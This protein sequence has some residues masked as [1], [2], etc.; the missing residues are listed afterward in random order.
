MSAAQEAKE[1]FGL[2]VILD[3][4]VD[5]HKI[6]FLGRGFK[7]FVPQGAKV[8]FD[9][10]GEVYAIDAVDRCRFEEVENGRVPELR[11][12]GVAQ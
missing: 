8:R 5:P 12:K 7:V 6:F 10:K 9:F 1:L 2:P 11:W 3:K 4:N